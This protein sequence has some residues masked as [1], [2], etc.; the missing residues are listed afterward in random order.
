MPLC[1]ITGPMF[2][3]KTTTL[4][5]R[6]QR[7]K[8][9]RLKSLIVKHSADNRYSCCPEIVSHDGL[10]L[11]L[12]S[13][14]DLI[15]IVNCSALS[16]IDTDL[17]ASVKCILID[18]GQFF[19]DLVEFCRKYSNSKNLVVSGLISDYKLDPFVRMTGLFSFTDEI[20]HNTSNCAVCGRETSF[21]ARF[22]GESK[23]QILIGASEAYQPRC[24][25][26]HPF[27]Q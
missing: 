12:E 18:E 21:T 17:I 2:S 5:S 3:G 6:S 7:F 27:L 26:H 14:C 11:K 22:S 8:I 20:N 13:E 4:I 16:D 15:Q 19:P 1:V 24:R 23:D 9:A 10:T 25:E